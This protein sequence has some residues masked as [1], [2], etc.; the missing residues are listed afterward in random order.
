MHIY[1]VGIGGT[2]IGPLALIAHQA[3]Y[4][5]SGSDKRDSQY[6][7][8]LKKHGIDNITIGDSQDDIVSTH[9]S[10]AID[11]LVHTS[12]VDF[13]NPNHEQLTWAKNNGIRISKRDE[14]LTELIKQKSSS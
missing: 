7:Q 12:A 1:F 9:Q 6:I 10:K 8:Y 11:W 3:G 5:V 4:E 2:A 13:E 14:L